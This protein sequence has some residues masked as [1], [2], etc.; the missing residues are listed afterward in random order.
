[1]KVIADLHIHSRF[2]MACSNRISIRALDEA[3]KSK[4]IDVLST[5]DALH[6]E[7]NKELKAHLEPAE[8]G[9]FK[10][11]DSANGT[12][13]ILGAEVSTIFISKEKTR[14]IHNCIMLTS[15]EAVSALSEILSKYG[16]LSSDGRPALSMSSA[17]LVEE[18]FR[19]DKNA[20]VFPAHAWTPYFGVFGS[21]SGFDSMKDAYEDQEK[22]IFALETGLSSDPPMNW[23]LSALDK[24][25]L[26]SNSDMHSLENMG[27]EAN[28]FNI[29]DLSYDSILN[30]IKDRDGKKFERTLE[31]YPEEGKY[32]YDGHRDCQYSIDPGKEKNQYCRVCGKKLVNGVLHRIN[33]LADRPEGYVPKGHIPYMHMVP[34]IEVI[35]YVMKKAKY[36]PKVRDKYSEMLARLGTEFDILSGLSIESI[37]DAA[38]EE[39]GEAISNVRNDKIRIM[40]GYDGVFGKLDLLSREKKQQNNNKQKGIQGFVK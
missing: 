15:F 2:A 34:L 33:E 7:W 21:L 24:Y 8:Q 19:A 6:P 5:G 22:H 40:P 31:F 9:M 18:L 11:R 35:S 37:K 36:S 38:G 26:V 27:R 23:R 14:K 4:G 39:I 16:N 10:V 20:L 17:H 25:A 30:S 32:H 28:V 12:R 29:N 13:F 1:M 3:A